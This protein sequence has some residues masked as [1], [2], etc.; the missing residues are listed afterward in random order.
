MNEMDLEFDKIVIFSN[1]YIILE[2]QK[3]FSMALMFTFDIP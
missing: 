2:I 3:Y 1:Q